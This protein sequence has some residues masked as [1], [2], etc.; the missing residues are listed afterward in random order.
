MSKWGMVYLMLNG[1]RVVDFSRYLPGPY[2]TQRLADMGAE[3]IKV[4]PPKTGDPARSVGD[5]LNGTGLVYLANNRNKK[6]VSI[7]LK[8][9]AGREIAFQL[10]SKADV[11][12]EGFRPGVADALGIGY[13]SLKQIRPNLVY[14]SLTGYGQT[15]PLRNLGGHDLNYMALSGVLSQLRDQE[16]RPVQPGI[17]FADLIGGIAAC[18]A[19]LASLVKKQMTGEGSY[20][21]ISITD[22]MIGMM[23]GHVMIQQVTGKGSGVPQL[24]GSIIS[25]FI[26]ET[27][28]NRFVSLGALEK[29]FWENFC[30]A[31]GREDWI[32]DHFSPAAENNQTFL[33][34][35][36]LFK[37]RTFAEWSQFS[38]EVDCCMAPVLDTGE[39]IQ[40]PHVCEKELVSNIQSN[41]WG[42]MFQT[43]TSA[44]GFGVWQLKSVDTAPPPV[45]SQ[46]NREVFQE[47]L[48]ASPEQVEEWERRGII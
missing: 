45:L 25:Y 41:E 15:G 27:K 11:V 20:L 30:R 24:G 3:V 23:T 8:E 36:A 19:I 44:G 5:H 48:N 34:I 9:P 32:A 43:A 29:K 7:N 42:T 13:K 38:L 21:D 40:H 37:T 2:A 26:Y 14:C 16:G 33:D 6:S 22:A 4:E 47:V 12:I 35:K 28:D 46:H 39:M 18:E 17:Q 31:V 1:I 10:A